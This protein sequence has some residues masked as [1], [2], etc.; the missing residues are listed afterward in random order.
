MPCCNSVF[1]CVCVYV[2]VCAHTGMREYAC[3][4]GARVGAVEE[5]HV[6]P[7]LAAAEAQIAA[8]GRDAP[9]GAAD[10]ACGGLLA[11]EGPPVADWETGVGGGRLRACHTTGDT[12]YVCG[13]EG[14]PVS[15]LPGAQH[16]QEPIAAHTGGR[17]GQ[18]D[19]GRW[20]SDGEPATVYSL[21][22]YPAYDNYAGTLY[23]SSYT[24]CMHSSVI[25]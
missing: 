13:D 12:L 23:N 24:L 22:A 19:R 8:A 6:E 17:E 2:C 5:T 14:N 20:A 1:V 18:Q 9:H 25:A 7:W 3:G 10:D 15:H 11:C 16:A 4:R 21:F